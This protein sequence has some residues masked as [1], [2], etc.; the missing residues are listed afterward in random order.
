MRPPDRITTPQI[1]ARWRRTGCLSLLAAGLAF[2]AFIFVVAG[3]NTVDSGKVGVTRNFGRITGT[4][5]AGGFWAQPIGFSMVEYDLRVAKTLE[6]QQAALKNQQ[7]LFVDKVA[8][9]YN[10]SPEAA[11]QLLET[12]GTQDT[13]EQNVV[14]PKLEN[15]I[16]GVTPRFTAEEV[17]PRRSDMETEMEKKLANDL[18]KYKVEPSSVDITLADI[19]FDEGYRA[20]IDAKAKAEQDKQVELANLE[21]Q[22]TKNL[23]EIQQAQT[24]AARA[25]L[26]AEG[27]ANATKARAQGEAESTRVK[28]SAQAQANKE[29]ATTL[30]PELINYQYAQNWNGQMP[31]TVFGQDG[32]TPFVNVPA[33]DNSPPAAKG[34]G[35]KKP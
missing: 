1:P 15:T 13:F 10:L 32:A 11:S 16:K 19:D 28:A 27:E 6:K 23:Q 3:W 22:K 7:T 31:T 9:Q 21:K 25:K 33:S 14:I 17:F 24:D 35:A 29:I 18:L 8:Y 4:H 20:S 2:V 12:V 34:N 26:A 5:V 30:T